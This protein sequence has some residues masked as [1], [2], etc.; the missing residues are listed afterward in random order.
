[1]RTQAVI[2]SI[3]DELV[4]G[5]TLDTN[6]AWLAA[7]LAERGLQAAWHQ[8]LP[9]DRDAIAEALAAASER[10]ELVLVTG[11]LGPTEDDLTRQALARAMG[12]P[13]E[14][15]EVSL[16]RIE[17]F[18]R[19]R[20]R[21]M[22]ER[23]RVQ[24][25]RPRGATMIDNDAGTAP[26]VFAELG[27][28]RIYIMP[29]V[30]WEMKRM[31]G[32]SIEPDVAGLAGG[33][34]VVLAT[35]INTFGDGESDAAERLGELM[36]RRRNPK[37]GTTVTGGIVSVRV[38]SEFPTAE[39]AKDELEKTV[40]A[41]IE[42]LGAVVFGRDED[43]LQDAVVRL[44]ERHGKRL[45]TA[46]SCTGGLIGAM[47]ADVP[48]CSQ[49]YMGGWV[50][51]SN[52][53]KVE[54]LGVAKEAL[55]SVGAV[56]EEVARAMAAGA[57]RKA[58]GADFSLAVTGIAG[59]EG[60]TKEKPVGTVWLA[61]G[62]RDEQDAGRVTTRALRLTLPGGRG[63]VRDRAAKCALQMLR[64]H[65]LGEPLSRLRWGKEAQTRD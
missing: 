52:V 65:L 20:G 24:A 53:L 27:R 29:G 63:A 37:L 51:Y 47:I 36:D 2:L 10:A 7:K 23:N 61:L 46:E 1:M 55:E 50:T 13:L 12:Q 19:E 48:G 28:A 33:R 41:V 64:L 31:W 4:L 18:Y 5:Q 43:T 32:Q 62:V 15:D 11:G 17:A 39:R 16:A 26:G 59:P 40:A 22:P 54:Q 44:L 6:G 14:L 42:R 56:S 60:G 34:Q 3:G 21:E 58:M 9:D 45:V 57:I 30:P 38:R 35:K 49:S 8:T 25:M